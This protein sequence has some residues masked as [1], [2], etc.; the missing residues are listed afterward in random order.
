MSE[1]TNSDGPPRIYKVDSQSIKNVHNHIKSF[2]RRLRLTD[3]DR[4]QSFSLALFNLAKVSDKIELH[5]RGENFERTVA[6]RSV[7]DIYRKSRRRGRI[8]RQYSEIFGRVEP[9][10]IGAY[11]PQGFQSL[12]LEEVR[13]AFLRIIHNTARRPELGPPNADELDAPNGSTR[14][15]NPEHVWSD[16]LSEAQS[17]E[18]QAA[19]DNAQPLTRSAHAAAW[20]RLYDVVIWQDDLTWRE[21]AAPFQGSAESIEKAARPIFCAAL[22]EALGRLPEAP[23]GWLRRL[24]LGLLSLLLPSALLPRR[25][26]AAVPLN[27]SLSGARVAAP[28]KIALGVGVGLA[29]VGLLTFTFGVGAVHSEAAVTASAPTNLSAPG[30]NGLLHVVPGAPIPSA[31]RPGSAVS[32]PPGAA[33]PSA[34]GTRSSPAASAVRHRAAALAS[35]GSL[36][37]VAPGPDAGGAEATLPDPAPRAPDAPG[38][39]RPQGLAPTAPTAARIDVGADQSAAL[40]LSE[41]VRF[42]RKQGAHAEAVRLASQGAALPAAAARAAAASAVRTGDHATALRLLDQAAVTQTFGAA[43]RDES[44]LRSVALAALGQDGEAR[45]ARAT[46]PPLAQA[47]AWVAGRLARATRE[48]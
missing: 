12:A 14:L 41:R 39:A 27:T 40:E 42:A 3:I 6:E 33:H 22:T 45:A 47:R 38:W 30:L 1:L 36:S 37:A 11:D 29:V 25:A 5:G 23:V 10:Q 46:L 15:I 9:G 4:E 16:R 20:L 32:E 44:H 31:A 35:V 48:R 28:L 8:E 26:Q 19:L 2:A 43:A 24:L 7:I 13:L 34:T 17:A 18:A 21:V